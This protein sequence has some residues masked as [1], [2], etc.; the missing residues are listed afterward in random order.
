[1]QQIFF[2]EHKFATDRSIIS[3]LTVSSDH[4]FSVAS[5]GASEPVELSGFLVGHDL[6]VSWPHGPPLADGRHGDN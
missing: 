4:Y 1:L 5:A 3:S 6:L 2:K